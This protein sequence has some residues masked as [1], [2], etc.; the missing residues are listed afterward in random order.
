[1]TQFRATTPDT[2]ADNVFQLIGEDWALLTGGTK[3]KCNPMT[4]SWGGLGVLWN[5]NVCFVFV[6]PQRH[7]FPERLSRMI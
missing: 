1:M 6:R 7:T 4:V 3:E 2:L 5:K